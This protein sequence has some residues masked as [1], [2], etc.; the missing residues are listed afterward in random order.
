[1]FSYKALSRFMFYLPE[2]GIEFNKRT[3]VLDFSQ[4]INKGSSIFKE[5]GTN[6]ERKVEYIN[7]YQY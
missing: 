3:T 2:D 1:M 5:L 4:S 7:M 6:N